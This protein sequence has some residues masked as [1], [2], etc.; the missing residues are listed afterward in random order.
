MVWKVKME[1]IISECKME[2]TAKILYNKLKNM[3]EENVKVYMVEE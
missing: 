2:E 1:I 3:K